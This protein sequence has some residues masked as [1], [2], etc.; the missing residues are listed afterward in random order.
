MTGGIGT[1]VS[2][3]D[4]WRDAVARF[5]AAPAVRDVAEVVSYAEFDA[6]MSAVGAAVSALVPVGA[7]VAV[8]VPKTVW[9]LAAMFGVSR[10]GRTALILDPGDP[11]ERWSEHC[12]RVAA[13]VAFSDDPAAR[14]SLADLGLDVL[15][16]DDLSGGADV[17]MAV[18]IDP[19][20]DAWILCTSGST[21]V[22]KLVGIPQAMLAEAWTRNRARLAEWGA[23][24]S[25][26]LI[27]APLSAA[28]IRMPLMLAWTS[29]MCAVLVDTPRTPPER[30]LEMIDEY[31]VHRLNVDPWLLRA[32]VAAARTRGRG[33]SSIVMI[34]TTGGPIGADAVAAAWRWFP[35]AIVRSHYGAT[36]FSGIANLEV[37]PGTDLGSPEAFAMTVDSDV[38]VLIATDVAGTPAPPGEQGEIWVRSNRALGRYHDAPDLVGRMHARGPD[39]AE[40]VRTGDLGRVLADGRLFVDGRDDARVKLN[41]IAVDLNAVTA[42]VR[43]L[44]GVGDAEVSV[45]DRGDDVRLV[46]WVVADGGAFLSVRELR[47]GLAPHLPPTMMPHVFRAVAAIPRLRTGKPDRV[48]LQI[49]ASAALPVAGA[50]VLPST[51]LEQALAARFE[52]ALGVDEVGIHDSFSE[53]GGDSLA[54]LEMITA[55]SDEFGVP[56]DRQGLLEQA[57]VTEGSVSA[58]ARAIEHRPDEADAEVA[59]LRPDGVAMLVLR[60]DGPTADSPIVLLSG[61]GQTPLALRPLVQRLPGCRVWTLLPRGFRTR[62]RPDRS[63][64]EIADRFAD[65]LMDAHP[66]GDFVLAGFS[67]GGLVAQDLARV[68]VNRGGRV[69]LLA[70]LDVDRPGSPPRATPRRRRWWRAPRV[71]WIR[72]RRWCRARTV[73]YLRHGAAAQGE[74]FVGLARQWMRDLHAQPVDVPTMV[75]RSGQAAAQGRPPDLGWSLVCR[76]RLETIDVPGGHLGVLLEPSVARIGEILAS[77]AV[78][79]P[80][81]G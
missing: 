56:A 3:T 6:R 8:A 22:P 40:W 5:D 51:P 60:D 80:E 33:S 58:L 37:R 21:G 24:G 52:A 45:V 38:E 39:G 43:A 7:V 9:S 12:L 79:L 13:T 69:R 32:L 76:G 75:V 27:V 65:A 61:G 70:L 77:A 14:G 16:P 2:F 71:V 63:V 15:G 30:L 54:A 66:R 74:A 55:L 57:M 59:T 35:E 25:P 20:A 46:A 47:T 64:A 4:H 29:G 44:D 10:V 18:P 68:I 17:A 48:A 62:V 67:F 72:V 19:S 31:G 34:A 23:S 49:A 26:T 50:R 36:E 42:A 81:G 78:T 73:G 41:G 11:P 1:F 53:L 28:A